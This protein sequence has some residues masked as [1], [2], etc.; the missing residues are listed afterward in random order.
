[1]P[2]FDRGD[3]ISQVTDWGG[4]TYLVT[5]I[6]TSHDTFPDAIEYYNLQTL[7]HYDQSMLGRRVELATWLIDKTCKLKA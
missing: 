6:A 2:K 7:Q 3:I 1:M 5:D 4:I